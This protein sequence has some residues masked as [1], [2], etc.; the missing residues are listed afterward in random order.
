MR[1]LSIRTLPD[2]LCGFTLGNNGLVKL[3]TK[4]FRE[5]VDSVVA[6]DLDGFLGGVQ[7]HM[8]VAAPM[9]VFVEFGAYSRGHGAIQIIGQLIQKVF[10]VHGWPS[11]LFLDL[12]YFARRSRSCKRARNNLDFTAGMLNP[13]ISA[14]SSVESPST[15]RSTNTALNPGGKP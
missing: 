3:L 7:D 1:D 15:S 5:F 9:Q 6:I 2:L 10:A 8:A 4:G 11:P 12:K 13:N 14:V